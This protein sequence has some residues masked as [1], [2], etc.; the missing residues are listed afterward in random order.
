VLVYHQATM[1]DSEEKRR[2]TAEYYLSLTDGEL[3]KI[4]SEAWSLTEEGKQALEIELARRGLAVDLAKS[5]APDASPLNLVTLRRFRDN[6]EALLAQ[7]VLESAGLE[8]FLIDET[9]I[10]MDWLW[11]NA[12]G[13]VKLCVKPADAHAAL[14]LLDQSVPERFDVA[15]VGNYEQPRC[16][17][18]SSVDISFRDIDKRTAYA[19]ILFLG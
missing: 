1:A 17:K 14:E 15:G 4:A 11:S 13:G 5:P 8:G 16:P 3:A 9:T 18:C 2:R 12:L 19:G 7:G 10:R 6:S